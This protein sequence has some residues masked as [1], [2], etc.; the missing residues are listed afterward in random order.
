[1]R[2]KRFA[3]CG[4]SRAGRAPPEQAVV[5]AVAAA[6]LVVAVGAGQTASRK[7]A[8]P[9]A[10]TNVP[11][12]AVASPALASPAKPSVG[13]AEPLLLL[14]D[15]PEE[16]P[17]DITGADNSRC[18]VCHLN[19][20]HE[21]LSL[22]HARTNIGCIKC[23]GPCDAHI[24]DES[25]ASGGNGTPPEIMYPRLKINEGCL[26]CHKLETVIK[27]RNHKP[28]EVWL[29]AYQE[30]VCTDCHG[31]HRMVNRKCKWK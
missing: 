29:L 28:E 14:D 31:K 2:L 5:W 19:F 13:K 6:L 10:P 7:P 27:S 12:A 24:A 23:H 11:P 17:E 21:P 22:V 3:P 8:T 1:M 26:E 15:A 25:W 30:M 18:Q 20:M 4:F 16:K 9:G